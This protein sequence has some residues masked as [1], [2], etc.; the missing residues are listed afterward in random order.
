MCPTQPFGIDLALMAAH[1]ILL[2]RAMMHFRGTAKISTCPQPR[3]GA[4]ETVRHALWE[5][6]A[7]RDLWAMAGLLS[8]V[9]D[10]WTV[11]GLVSQRE[12]PAETYTNR[13][14]TINVLKTLFGP[15][16]TCW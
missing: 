8:G 15:T 7:A 9:P 5:C 14:L 1:E 11:I 4:P 12:L 13:W 16:E 2:V 6:S 3:C 10:Y